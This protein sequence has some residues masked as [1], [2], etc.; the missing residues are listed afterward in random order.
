MDTHDFGEIDYLRLDRLSSPR[1]HPTNGKTIIYRRKQ[2]HMPDLKAS[3]ITLHWINLET[4]TT[5]Q[6]TRPIWGIN[7]Q[8]VNISNKRN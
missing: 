5:V 2:Y 6:L 8:Q 7:D 1:F 3:S 4:N